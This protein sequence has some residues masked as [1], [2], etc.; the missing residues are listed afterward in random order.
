MAVLAENLAS[1][2]ALVDPAAVHA[3]FWAGGALLVPAKG[4]LSKHTF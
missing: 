2:G 4:C 3:W 1:V